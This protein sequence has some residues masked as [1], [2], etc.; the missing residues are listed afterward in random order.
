MPGSSSSQRHSP[1]AASA[2]HVL[3][4][5]VGHHVPPNEHNATITA[6]KA[7]PA[8]AVPIPSVGLLPVADHA[9]VFR[10]YEQR[11]SLYSHTDVARTLWTQMNVACCVGMVKQSLLSAFDR[12]RAAMQAVRHSALQG[13]APADVNQL[14]RNSFSPLAESLMRSLLLASS[15]IHRVT[16]SL[17]GHAISSLLPPP[18]ALHTMPPYD[19]RHS[20]QHVLLPMVASATIASG[21]LPGVA[22]AHE[23]LQWRCGQELQVEAVLGPAPW[24]CSLADGACDAAPQVV[25][26][27]QET[28]AAVQQWAQA[29]EGAMKNLCLTEQQLLEPQGD[30]CSV[31]IRSGPSA[32]GSIVLHGD[33]ARPLTLFE[34]VLAEHAADFAAPLFCATAA[35][36]T[37]DMFM[38]ASSLCGGNALHLVLNAASTSHAI[39]I[40]R[41]AVKRIFPGD[42]VS[43]S[44]FSDVHVGTLHSCDRS[45]PV[46]V[47]P[48][49]T[50]LLCFARES[51]LPLLVA[52]PLLDPRYNP[53][54]DVP[55]QFLSLPPAGSSTSLLI[56]PCVARL[57]PAAASLSVIGFIHIART[58][59][60]SLS[61]CCFSSIELTCIQRLAQSAADLMQLI[62][63]LRSATSSAHMPASPSF[64]NT[65]SATVAS[66]ARAS[67]FDVDASSPKAASSSKNADFKPQAPLSSALLNLL[68]DHRDLALHL[69]RTVQSQHSDPRL[70]RIAAFA[71]AHCD[72]PAAQSLQHSR[73]VR[74]RSWCHSDE[75]QLLA[76]LQT[77]SPL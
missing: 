47:P 40:I 64:A 23:L 4:S 68:T 45:S 53:A 65:S 31:V 14:Q 28:Q 75:L 7:E 6:Q 12:E 2:V 36:I 29:R 43:A 22:H 16:L 73:C 66:F 1:S 48:D 61:P 35:A 34:L 51:Q 18:P 58:H 71:L 25:N 49:A 10:E 54:L 21:G 20:P 56:V 13:V 72:A 41:D 9:R 30:T 8:D 5:L 38:T 33:G 52:D 3:K 27:T 57:H 46:D 59:T 67:R 44:V 15:R 76:P 70:R 77:S 74:A 55:A 50:G 69:F 42:A 24:G 37:N 11:S 39:A 19:T 26:G 60:P 62:P 32:I 63:Q 17:F